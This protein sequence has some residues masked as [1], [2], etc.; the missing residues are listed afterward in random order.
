MNTHSA[1]HPLD[2]VVEQLR[3][4]LDG[5]VDGFALV[6][7]M[8]DGQALGA[9]HLIAVGAEKLQVRVRVKRTLFRGFLRFL[10]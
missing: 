5:L 10:V 3:V 2:T 9:S 4:D 8:Q 1:T 7:S 6:S